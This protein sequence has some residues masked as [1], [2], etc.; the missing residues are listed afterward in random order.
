MAALGADVRHL[1]D[2][3]LPMARVARYGDVRGTEAAH[4]EPIFVGMFE[5]ALVGI[6]AAC[7]A[8]D[9]D[10]A[11]RMVESMG[12]VNEALQILNRD[13]LHIEWRGCLD[14]L[15]RKAVPAIVRGWCCR[16]LLDAR[17]ISE[18]ELYRLARLSLSSANP[19]AEC[20]AWATGLLRGSGLALLHQDALWQVFD[21]WL[22]ELSAD[23]FVEMLPLLRRAFADFTGPERRHMGEKVKHLSSGSGGS[24]VPPGSPADSTDIDHERASPG[25]TDPGAYPWVQVIL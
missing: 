3:L 20:A 14:R 9:D 7:S 23:V 15:M 4:I 1:M 17:A 18:A 8:L 21:R 13:D 5:R 12:C 11:L 10:A 2:A 22:S 16:L 24:L 19:P 25:V 6:A